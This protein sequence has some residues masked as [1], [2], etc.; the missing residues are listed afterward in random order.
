MKNKKLIR[1]TESDLHRIIKESVV[2]VLREGK[3]VNN[4]YSAFSNKGGVKGGD[5]GD[6]YCAHNTP[7]L[8]YNS[9]A[10]F[11]RDYQ[12]KWFPE[13]YNAILKQSEKEGRD[14]EDVFREMQDK[15]RNRYGSDYE[16][17]VADYEPYYDKRNERRRKVNPYEPTYAYIG[18]GEYMDINDGY[19]DG[20][21]FE[22][23]RYPSPERLKHDRR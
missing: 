7:F 5:V 23:E 2:K 10:E 11:E 16:V 17:R 1:L 19:Y 20:D 4:K 8:T 13:I 3:T 6:G 12:G 18:N 22:T 9:F 15:N 21:D 14:P